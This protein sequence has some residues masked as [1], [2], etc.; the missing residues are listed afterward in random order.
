[1]YEYDQQ[2]SFIE[3]L[4]ESDDRTK[5][6]W[7][8]GTTAAVMGVVIYVWLGYFGG[9][10]SSSSVVAIAADQSSDTGAHASISENLKKGGAALYG[11]FMDKVGALGSILDAP[12]QY[13]IK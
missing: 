6:R 4:Q 5:N 2:K 3:K 7:M 12:R 10:I 13:I 1:M 9:L 11:I 8:F